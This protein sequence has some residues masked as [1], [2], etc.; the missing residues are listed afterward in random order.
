MRYPVYEGMLRRDVLQQSGKFSEPCHPHM[1]QPARRNTE[2]VRGVTDGAPMSIRHQP[3]GG[4]ALGCGENAEGKQRYGG[5]EGCRH[6]RPS[7]ATGRGLGSQR[8]QRP[9]APQS[10]RA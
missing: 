8:N 7:C 3:L 6:D 2:R 9:Q 4:V 1:L 10:R 5:V